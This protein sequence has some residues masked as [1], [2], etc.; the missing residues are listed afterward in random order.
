MILHT[1]SSP[2][3]HAQ[4]V[5]KFCWCYC[6]CMSCICPGALQLN[7]LHPYSAPP[8]WLSIVRR[9]Q[10]VFNGTSL[11]STVRFF[12]RPSIP[13][14]RSSPSF[15]PSFLLQWLYQM[16]LKPGFGFLRCP[17]CPLAVGGLEREG[18]A[19]PQVPSTYRL[20]GKGRT[21][22][23]SALTTYSPWCRPG[24]CFQNDFLKNKANILMNYLERTF[25]FKH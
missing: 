10:K 6:L 12:L 22:D 2:V 9:E 15:L 7:Q 21:S 17:Q 18:A 25:S 4:P 23:S 13:S 19:A 24:C 5:T 8:K 16:L 11:S 3:P 1:Q 14:F 20:R